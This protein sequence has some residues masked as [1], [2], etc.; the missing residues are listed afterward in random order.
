MNKTLVSWSILAILIL[1][2]LG[3]WWQ[4]SF[5]RPILCT[6]RGCVTTSS[7]AKE[8][9]YA[10]SFARLTNADT[11]P[12]QSILTTLI[13]IHLLKAFGNTSISENEAVKYRTSVLHL[14]DEQT[15]RPIGFSS[16]QEY[17]DSVTI[18]FLMQ[19]AYAKEHNLTTSDDVYA[20][21]A[22][23][24][25]VVSLLFRYAWDSSKGEAVA[26]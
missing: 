22:K 24:H 7:L 18:P 23:Q 13:R 19:E 3:I 25:R 17:D 21:L 9:T 5:A 20:S 15:I 16:F 8:K 26:R 14:T 10:Q 11:P 2:L 4:H 6:L 1:A 12:E